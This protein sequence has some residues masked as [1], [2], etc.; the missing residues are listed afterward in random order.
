MPL[1]HGNLILIYSHVPNKLVF[2]CRHLSTRAGS[3]RWLRRRRRRG[4][5]GR[6]GRRLFTTIFCCHPKQ[7]TLSFSHAHT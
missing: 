4:R 2:G 7:Q 3:R 6:R 1:S 5:R